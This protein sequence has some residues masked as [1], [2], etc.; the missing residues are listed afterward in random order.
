MK[1]QQQIKRTGRPGHLGQAARDLGVSHSHLWRVAHG[2]RR[3][4]QPTLKR[5]LEWRR[6]NLMAIGE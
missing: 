3:D 1:Q 2:K 5:Y 4:A 6:K